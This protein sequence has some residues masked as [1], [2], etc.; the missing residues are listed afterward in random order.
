MTRDV[1]PFNTNLRGIARQQIEFRKQKFLKDRGIAASLGF[2]LKVRDETT[3]KLLIPLTRKKL[4]SLPPTST[5]PFQP[6][7][8]LD[9]EHYDYILSVIASMSLVM[10]RS[11]KAFQKIREEDLRWFFLV[12][13]NGHY[14]GLATGET[15]NFEGKTDI[16]I[17]ANNRNIFISECKFWKGAKSLIEAIDQL[18]NY[19]S[20]RDTKTALLIFSRNKQL[21]LVLSEICE[22]VKTHQNFKRRLD[23]PSETGFRYILHHR[24][25]ANRELTLTIL[26]F[27]VPK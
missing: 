26:V 13:L 1:L 19:V 18:L 20:W 22:T 25:D 21:S 5:K 7:P 17:K 8:E 12:L 3:Q 9:M 23:Y 14:E 10:E 24:D 6:E 16:V 27:D 15:F 11:P 2:P 4:P